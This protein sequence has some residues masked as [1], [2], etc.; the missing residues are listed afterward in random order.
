MSCV[1]CGKPLPAGHVHV[2]TCSERCYRTLLDRQ[3]RRNEADDSASLLTGVAAG[4]ALADAIA[5]DINT[6]DTSTPSDFSG[7]GGD[8]GGGGASG[9]W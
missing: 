8:F 7:G 9:S 2:D 3:R 1:I 4:V 5:T 6:I